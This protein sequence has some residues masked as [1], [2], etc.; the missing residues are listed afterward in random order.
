MF[1]TVYISAMCSEWIRC[2][3]LPQFNN[4]T[5]KLCAVF[6]SRKIFDCRV[7]AQCSHSFPLR[8]CR[9]SLSV[10]LQFAV[11]AAAVLNRRAVYCILHTVK[12]LFIFSLHDVRGRFADRRDILHSDRKYAEFWKLDPKIRGFI[13]IGFFQTLSVFE[14]YWRATA[15]L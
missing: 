3:L 14:Y 1:E 15:M 7:M 2:T 5:S 6:L 9:S 4:I 13:P 8:C 12:L 11:C 10:C